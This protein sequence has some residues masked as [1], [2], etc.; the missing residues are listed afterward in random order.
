VTFRPLFLPKP[1]GEGTNYMWAKSPI[2][3][4][5]RLTSKEAE[6]PEAVS[7][8]LFYPSDL[9]S[10]GYTESCTFDFSFFGNQIRAG[11]KSWRTTYDGVRRLISSGRIMTLGENNRP[12]FIQSHGDNPLQP[13]NNLWIDTRSAMDKKY[14]VET[15]SRV[16]ERCILMTTDPGDLVVDPT[17]GSGTS[18][19][20][21]EKWGRRWITCDTSRVAVTLAKQRLMTAS[22]DYYELKYP[23]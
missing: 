5:R 17:C 19:Y 2:G 20:V 21:A 3:A 1:V 22:Y 23:H 11:K 16:V 10:S 18:A 9:A 13:I 15:D 6:N 12:C 4:K 7:D 14:V 8:Q